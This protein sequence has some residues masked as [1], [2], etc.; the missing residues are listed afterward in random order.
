[1]GTPSG[2]YKLDSLTNGFQNSDLIII[3]GRPSIGKTAF[4]LTISIN[5]I[6]YSKIPVLFFSLEMSKEQLIYRL[7]TM[8]ANIAQS[9][10]RNGNLYKRDWLKL[11]KVLKILT[12]LPFFVDDNSNLTLSLIHI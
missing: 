2:F 8:E 9:K 11:S 10:L 1:M 6:K 3:A 5:A 12:K 7:L 4:S